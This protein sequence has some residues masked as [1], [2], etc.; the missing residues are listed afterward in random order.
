MQLT[1]KQHYVP[2]FYLKPFC[3]VKNIGTNKEKCFISFYQFKDKLIKE[4]IPITSVCSENFF[5]DNDGKIEKELAKKETK[6]ATVFRH[7]IESKELK[8][9]DLISI[10]EFTIYQIAR[11]KAMLNHNQEM[12]EAIFTNAL[13][14]ITK[15]EI[16]KEITPEYNLKIVDKDISIISDLEILV[17][18][19]KTEIPFLTSDVPVIVTNPFSIYNTGIGN[20]GTVM[21]FPISQYKM[22]L[23]YDSKLYGKIDENIVSKEVVNA[24]NKYQFISSDE[25]VLALKTQEFSEYLMDNNLFEEKIKCQEAI[26]P[27]TIH[28][29]NNTLTVTKSKGIKYCYNISIFKLPEQL[30]MIPMDFRLMFSIP[31]KYSFDVKCD[32]LTRLYKKPDFSDYPILKNHWKLTQ[33]YS[34]KF[35]S[36]LDVY[37]NTPEKDKNIDSEIIERLKKRSITFIPTE[38]IDRYIDLLNSCINCE[39]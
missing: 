6:W 39:F 16:E 25:R 17:L 24:F 21:F 34:E 14:S 12:A 22:V 19:N 20:I 32:I 33:E 35:L 23:L 38:N 37:W 3:E 29:N 18:I 9:S 31:R 4:G 30:K 27:D 26:K 15:E 10:R 7:I 1:I 11:T 8:E 5:Y 2:R 36:Y 28:D 13:E